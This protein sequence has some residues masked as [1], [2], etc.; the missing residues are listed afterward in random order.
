MSQILMWQGTTHGSQ[1]NFIPAGDCGII[2]STKIQKRGGK[3]MYYATAVSLREENP[4]F[5]SG[6]YFLKTRIAAWHQWPNCEGFNLLV[7]T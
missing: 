6:C 1:I 7:K 5:Y 4:L 3:D 2:K